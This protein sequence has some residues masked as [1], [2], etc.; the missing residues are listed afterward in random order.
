MSITLSGVVSETTSGNRRAEL[1]AGAFE[2]EC[3]A[4]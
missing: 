1:V 4:S 2:L 3:V